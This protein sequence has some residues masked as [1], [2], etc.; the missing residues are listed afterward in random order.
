VRVCAIELKKLLGGKLE[1]QC[2]MLHAIVPK[3]KR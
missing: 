1:D 3:D 2:V